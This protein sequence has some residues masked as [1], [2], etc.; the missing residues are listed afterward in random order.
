M[1][2]KFLATEFFPRVIGKAWDETDLQKILTVLPPLSA[3][4]PWLGGGSLRRTVSNM[5]LE[6]DFDF[7]FSDQDQIGR[8]TS[9]LPSLGLSK[10]KETQHHEQWEGYI[11]AIERMVVLQCIKFQ[12]YKTAQEV[13]DS[14][15]FSICQFS[16]D[17]E[18]V[19][20]SD[21]ALWD[22]GRR[23]LA[24]NKITFPVSSMRRL[25]KYTRQGFT[26][27]D[28]C[29]AALSLAIAENPQLADNMNVAYV[30]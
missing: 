16:Y 10:K 6:S 23:R 3:Q 17:G 28:G 18:N 30:D 15:D 8:F 22:L 19:Y 5:P 1:T 11:P 21:Y 12:Y 27:C 13:I 20:C 29:L 26:A 14:F 4:G 7:F 24:V 25:L 2:Q 9:A